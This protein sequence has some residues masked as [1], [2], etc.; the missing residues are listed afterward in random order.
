M[1]YKAEGSYVPYRQYWHRQYWHRLVEVVTSP[2]T[3]DGHFC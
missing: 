3:D 2:N 1:Y